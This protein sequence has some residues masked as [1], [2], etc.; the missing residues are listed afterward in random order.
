MRVLLIVGLAMGIAASAPALTVIGFDSF[1]DGTP[2]GV[3]FGGYGV[4]FWNDT[5]NSLQVTMAYPGPPFT[6]PSS[7][8]DYA[9]FTGSHNFA[10]FLNGPATYVSVCMGDND[11]DEDLVYLEAYDSGGNLVASDSGV[12]PDYLYGGVTLEVSAPEIASVKFWSDGQGPGSVYFDNFEFLLVPEPG[13]VSLL[14]LGVLGFAGLLKKR[15][16]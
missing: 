1:A 14:G 9:G 12:V 15:L 5:T 16:A 11:Q 7:V 2:V 13:L 6:A 4:T 10:D 3:D 8:I